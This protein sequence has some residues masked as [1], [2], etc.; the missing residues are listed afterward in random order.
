MQILPLSGIIHET[1]TKLAVGLKD[2]F[3]VPVKKLTTNDG[4]VD[5]LN[6]VS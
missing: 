5:K 1:T 2:Y 4:G 6:L 3:V